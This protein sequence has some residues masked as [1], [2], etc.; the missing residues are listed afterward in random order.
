[1]KDKTH[2]RRHL[3][4]ARIFFALVAGLFL[5]PGL[6][7]QPAMD[8][9]V[10]LVFETSSDM[11]KRLPSVRSGLNDA[12]SSD[13]G[14]ELQPGDS[15]GVWTFDRQLHAGQ[16]P[17]Q[18]WA[19]ETAAAMVSEI[20]AFVGKQHYSGSASFNVLQA[21]MGRLVQNSERLTVLIFC[22]GETEIT[23]TPFDAGINQIFKEH[24]AAQKKAKRPF[25]IVLR[26]QLGQYVGC[27]VNFPPTPMNFPPFPPL[28]PP[29]EPPAPKPETT[30]T[31][32]PLPP[33]I[34]V[35]TTVGTNFPPPEPKPE[36]TNSAPPVIT[37]TVASNTVAS[38]TTNDS[39]TQTN[40]VPAQRE[41]SD[42]GGIASLAIGLGFLI[43]AAA[44][45]VFVLRRSRKADGSSLITQTIKKD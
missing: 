39:I 18:S 38:I 24:Q 20:V 30:P 13:M 32:A 37:N 5:I 23:G 8:N 14:D 27:T 1:M 25:I 17:L 15:F 33:L 9:R 6:R 29:P 35:G 36:P 45:A 2:S 3:R 42:P 22:D 7:A 43:A 34:I 11:K 19:P 26:T 31:P 44:L 21:P 41:S 16:F 10:L 40:S 28:P 4:A 12:M